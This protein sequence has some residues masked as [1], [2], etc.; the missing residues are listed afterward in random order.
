MKP[1]EQSW[2]WTKAWQRGAK[3]VQREL[4]EKGPGKAYTAKELLAEITNA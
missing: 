4:D 2:F 1:K 3:E